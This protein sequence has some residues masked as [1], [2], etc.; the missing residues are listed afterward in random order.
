MMGVPSKEE[1]DRQAALDS[2]RD[3]QMGHAID[4]PKCGKVME[5]VDFHFNLEAELETGEPVLEELYVCSFCGYE[6]THHNGQPIG[7]SQ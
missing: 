7:G 6:E 5:L 4:C 2:L 1:M 3:A